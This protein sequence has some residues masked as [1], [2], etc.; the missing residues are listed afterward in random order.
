M[1]YKQLRFRFHQI[2]NII[3]AAVLTG[4]SRKNLSL[5]K[6]I[7]RHFLANFFSPQ[8]FLFLFWHI[9]GS[10]STFFLLSKWSST[11]EFLPHL[12]SP[13]ESRQTYQIFEIVTF[14]NN[15]NH[16]SITDA[17]SFIT[18]AHKSAVIIVNNFGHHICCSL[19]FYDKNDST[20]KIIVKIIKTKNK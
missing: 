6:K 2:L 10:K 11:N 12:Y 5:E 7:V 20:K 3:D 14:W 8:L 15:F 17:W 18:I 1:A 9:F 19:H 4:Q 13:V 16:N